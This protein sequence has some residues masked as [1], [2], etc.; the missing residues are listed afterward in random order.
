MKSKEINI[1]CKG[2]G[3]TGT[4]TILPEITQSETIAY[5]Y[6]CKWCGNLFK[7]TITKKQLNM[8]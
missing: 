6:N 2:C 8:K 7:S 4:K 3:K 5:E 1:K